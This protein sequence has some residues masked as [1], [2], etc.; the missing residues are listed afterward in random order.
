MF[1]RLYKNNMITLEYKNPKGAY[2]KNG[3]AVE[4]LSYQKDLEKKLCQAEAEEKIR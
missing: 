3:Q 4:A 2:Y 1:N